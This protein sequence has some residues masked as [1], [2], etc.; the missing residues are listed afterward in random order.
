MRPA[1]EFR[2]GIRASIYQEVASEYYDAFRHPTCRDLGTLSGQLL[3]EGVKAALGGDLHLVEVGTGASLLAP[4]AAA[5]DVLDRVILI[6]SSA[7]MLS[8]S[9]AWESRGAELRVAAA[10]DTGLPMASVSLLVSSLGDPYNEPRFWRE[11]KRVLEPGGIC[12]FT[13]PSFAWSSRFRTNEARHYAEFLRADGTALFMPSFIYEEAEQISM[14]EKEGLLVEACEGLG[15]DALTGVVA[16][17][18]QCVER[19][20]PIV[21]AYRITSQR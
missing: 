19:G 12:L 14:I 6:D 2:I 21:T 16:P 11:V 18:L 15:A 3:R 10:A 17:K 9:K 13:T 1:A 20:T 8:Y 4:V 7:G 5:K